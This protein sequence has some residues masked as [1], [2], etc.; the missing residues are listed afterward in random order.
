[1]FDNYKDF[2]IKKLTS[3][4][5]INRPNY[6]FTVDYEEDFKLINK[7]FEYFLQHKEF[8]DMKEIIDFM[9]SNKELLYIN[10]KLHNGFSR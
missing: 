5:T 9:D 6:Y 1:M 7:I 10:A 3:P 2:K 8:F 4:K